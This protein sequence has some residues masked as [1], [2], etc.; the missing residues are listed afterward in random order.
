MRAQ[1]RH[2]SVI[3]VEHLPAVVQEDLVESERSPFDESPQNTLSPVKSHLGFSD[4]RVQDH[5]LALSTHDVRQE[6]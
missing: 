2:R 4:A 6:L 3:L 5:R 1:H